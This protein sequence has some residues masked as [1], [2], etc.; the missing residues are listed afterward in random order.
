MRTLD[1]YILRLFLM[2]L[3]ILFAV[4]IGLIILLD[5]ITNFDEFVQAAQRIEGGWWAHAWGVMNAMVDFYGPILFLLFVY[6]VGLPPVGAAGF[7]LAALIRNR[8]LVAMMAGGISLHRVALPILVV[9]FAANV[10]MVADQE[11]V[12]PAMAQKLGRTRAEIKLGQIRQ[13]PIRLMPD[14]NGSLFTAAKFDLEHNTLHQVSI[15]R[16]QK[17]DD[18][19]F[20]RATERIS[21]AQAIWDDKNKG[22]QLENGYG[23]MNDLG[24]DNR[25]PFAE[26][27]PVEVNFIASDLDPISI[28][29]NKRAEF[30]K[31]LSLRQLT[32][33]IH[34]SG[35]VDVA[36]LERIR[37]SRFSLPVI[38]MLIL[39]M[40][41]PFFLVRAPANLLR[42]SIKAAV[43]CIGAWA[44]GFIMLQIAPGALPPAAIAWMPVAMYL[45][46][47]FYRM[48]TVET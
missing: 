35:A 20:G 28:M 10:L 39:M 45:P 30:R 38:N 25:S 19:R 26:R 16:R 18:A 14:G 5:L 29:L 43:V 1:R 46:M 40:G 8:E 24:T 2:N 9:G 13:T 42:Q 31:L 12:L 15:L 6:L 22:W 3:V 21:A 27:K 17:I 41:V 4:M 23:L 7:T 37:H 36:D 34:S 11:L 33:L 48:D 47:A 32:E 44:S